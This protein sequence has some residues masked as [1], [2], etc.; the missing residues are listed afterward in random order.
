MSLSGIILGLINIAIVVVI[1]L[2]VGA[3]CKWVLGMLGWG[4]PTEVEK[5]FL[6]VVA[7]TA[8]YLLAALLL[9]LPSVHI[10][11]RGAQIEGPHVVSMQPFTRPCHAA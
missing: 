11:G 10:I 6:A 5:L 4:P 7:L 8:L 9:G 3:I 1:L 2:L